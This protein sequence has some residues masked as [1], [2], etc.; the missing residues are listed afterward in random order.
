[1][2]RFVAILALVSKSLERIALIIACSGL[3]L[4]T[5]SILIQIL[6]RYIF[7]EPL[8][9]TEELAR[10]AMIWSGFSGATVAYYRRADPVLFNAASIK[11]AWM[12]RS[13]QFIEVG[14]VITFCTAVLAASPA[15]MALHRT[16]F[17]ETLQAP[18]QIVVAIIPLSM[19]V[20]L[21]H[22]FV[23]LMTLLFA[24]AAD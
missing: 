22:A 10:H 5:I 23:R 20:I 18:T 19:G 13:A 14:A 12:R 17:T 7:S 9:W 1:V 11:R 15:F 24:K 4:M 8:A 16:M 6:A 21:Y 2:T 3:V